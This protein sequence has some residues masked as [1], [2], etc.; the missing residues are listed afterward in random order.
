ADPHGRM[1]NLEL[2]RHVAAGRQARYGSLSEVGAEGGQHLILGI[3]GDEMRY[4]QKGDRA[5]PTCAAGC[6]AASTLS[7]TADVWRPSPGRSF[8]ADGNT[9]ATPFGIDHRDC[10]EAAASH[11]H[12]CLAPARRRAERLAVRQPNEGQG[13]AGG[14]WLD[15]IGPRVS[16]KFSTVGEEVAV[17]GQRIGAAQR[18]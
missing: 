7:G 4:R 5:E 15:G 8:Y 16:L 3:A 6:H 9:I 14:H 17:N 12:L 1:G 18:G 10:V 2:A 11:R 13:P